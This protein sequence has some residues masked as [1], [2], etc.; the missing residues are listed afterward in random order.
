MK[1]LLFLIDIIIL[2]C[3]MSI[4]AFFNCYIFIDKE[5][6]YS[7]YYSPIF[8]IILSL[9]ILFILFI[10]NI[11]NDYQGY[12]GLKIILKFFSYFLLL[13]GFTLI[14]QRGIKNNIYHNLFFYFGITGIILLVL[15]FFIGFYI[16]SNDETY[17][18]YDSQ[19]SRYTSFRSNRRNQESIL[20]SIDIKLK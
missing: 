8:F 13:L 12:H 17:E 7:D 18:I 5:N 15:S 9:I 6:L 16:I 11:T 14:N 2:V 3:L 19:I 4:I 1:F 20:D 10:I